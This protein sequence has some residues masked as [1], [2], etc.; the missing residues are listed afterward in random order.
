MTIAEHLDELRRRLVWASAAILIVF[1]ASWFF[2]DELME[3]L[4]RPHY[5]AMDSLQKSLDQKFLDGLLPQHEVVDRRPIVTS[6]TE[7]IVTYMKACFIV[8]L[9][10]AG[11]YVLWQI[12]GFIAAGLYKREKTFVHRYFPFA[13]ILFFAGV[14]FGYFFLIPL[15]LDFLANFG[16]ERVRQAIRISDYFSLFLTLTIALGLVFQIP[17]VMVILSRLGIVQPSAFRGKWKFVIVACFVIA[18]IV[19]PTPDPYNQSLLALSMYLLYEIGIFFAKIAYRERQKN[20][21]GQTP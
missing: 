9:F 13:L 12:W 1:I 20:L 11:P 14:A 4:L 2:R 6:Y 16:S 5:R 19:T 10:V 8:S 17:M 18:A 7:T 21:E 15:G 3:I